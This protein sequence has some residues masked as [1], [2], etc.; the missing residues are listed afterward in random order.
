[1]IYFTQD[2]VTKAI[3]IGY[4]KNPKQRRAGLQSSNANPLVLIGVIHGGL[5][6]ERG[7]HDKFAPFRLHGE[8]FKGDILQTVLEIVAKNPTDKPPPM[9]V[10]IIGDSDFTRGP[11]HRPENHAL[12]FQA[13]NEQHAMTPIAWVITGGERQV[14]VLA[15]QWAK[16]NKV[17][18]CRYGPNWKKYGRFAGFKV[19]PQ[20][21]R[22]MFDPKMVL[23]FLAEQPSSNTLS[24]IRQ[25]QKAKI[26][27]VIKGRQIALV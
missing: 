16:Q 4:S 23:A 5:E 12:V 17:E 9:N 13:L 10:I 2:T 14:D 18:V 19:G 6:H 21:L 27:V 11:F 24:L 7:L 20:M 26:E 22:A 1:V 3:K 15:W 25:A 8:W